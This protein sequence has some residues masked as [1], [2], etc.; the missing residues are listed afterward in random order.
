[1]P[2]SSG[3]AVTWRAR[4][5]PLTPEVCAASGPA[6]QRLMRRLP[7]MEPERLA[8]LRGGANN[9]YVVVIGAEADLPWVPG[10]EYFGRDPLAPHLYLPTALEPDVPVTLLDK[11]L[12]MM[13]MRAPL[14]IMC[15]TQIVIPL[16]GVLPLDA[17]YVSK[18]LRRLE[19]LQT[20]VP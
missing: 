3:F 1:M 5:A 9:D 19:K 18:W 12:H 13:F 11:A 16:D 20:G 7:A 15:S 2:E 14:A 10:V 6:A 17:T 4:T 8:R